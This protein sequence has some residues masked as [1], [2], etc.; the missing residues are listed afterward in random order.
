[1]VIIIAE[2]EEAAVSVKWWQH[3]HGVATTMVVEICSDV[4]PSLFA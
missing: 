2:A 4:H 3:N 1:M